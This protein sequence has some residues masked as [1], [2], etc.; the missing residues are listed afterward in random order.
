[1]VLPGIEEAVAASLYARVM[2]YLRNEQLH[3]KD[4]YDHHVKDDSY[5]VNNMFFFALPLYSLG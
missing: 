4:V 1:M 5:H 2:E 3:Q